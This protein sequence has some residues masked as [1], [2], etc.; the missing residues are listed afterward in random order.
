[1]SASGVD[2]TTIKT[3]IRFFPDGFI[4]IFPWHG[5]E[6]ANQPGQEEQQQTRYHGCVGALMVVVGRST[7]LLSATNEATSEEELY[8]IVCLTTNRVNDGDK[9]TSLFL[10]YLER[11]LS[12]GEQAIYSLLIY[13]LKY[14]NLINRWFWSY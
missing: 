6:P 10:F 1:M 5:N 2:S 12:K 14:L 9:E 4:L 7:V 11:A 8:W 3:T 13:F